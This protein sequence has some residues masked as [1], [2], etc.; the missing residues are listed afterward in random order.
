MVLEASSLV[1]GPLKDPIERPIEDS[2]RE[3]GELDLVEFGS[4]G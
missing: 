1:E 4:Y 2:T 3:L